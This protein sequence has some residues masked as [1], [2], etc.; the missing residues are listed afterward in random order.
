METG[1]GTTSN[2]DEAVALDEV[3]DARGR[4]AVHVAARARARGP[5][6][7]LR[8]TRMGRMARA[9]HQLPANQFCQM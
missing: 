6:D 1:G 2:K 9:S 4:T 3:N 5:H 7:V 8:P